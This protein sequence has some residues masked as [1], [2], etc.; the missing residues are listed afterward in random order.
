[1]N[2]LVEYL[3]IGDYKIEST[4]GKSS[5]YKCLKVKTNVMD[6]K[7][8]KK[9]TLRFVDAMIY[10]PGCTLDQFTQDYTDKKDIKREKGFF[11]YEASTTDNYKDYLSKTEPFDQKDFYSS[12]TKSDI[13]DSDYEI[14]LKDYEQYNLRSDYLLHYNELDTR[15]MVEPI[16]FLIKNFAKF[17]VDMLKQVSAASC[18]VQVKYSFPYQKFNVDEEYEISPIKIPVDY[19]LEYHNKKVENYKHQDVKAGRSAVNNVSEADYEIVK[20]MFENGVCFIS[21]KYIS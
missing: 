16:N 6:G 18:A 12:L 15:I 17:D 20:N 7:R 9:V 4:L 3:Y 14:Y 11:P 2:L 1:M 21:C 13:S 19:T 5:Y 10:A 8:E